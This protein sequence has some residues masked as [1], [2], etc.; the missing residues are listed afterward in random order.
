MNSSPFTWGAVVNTNSMQIYGHALK[1]CPRHAA[2]DLLARRILR[3]SFATAKSIFTNQ[4]W[5]IRPGQALTPTW[6]S[7]MGR[8]SV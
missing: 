1:H 2:S 7:W 8:R 3:S 6:M 5:L 4:S